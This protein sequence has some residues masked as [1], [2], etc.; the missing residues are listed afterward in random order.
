MEIPK[1]RHLTEQAESQR[2]LIFRPVLGQGNFI[3]R[4]LC[5]VQP[6]PPRRCAHHPGWNTQYD[7]VLAAIDTYSDRSIFHSLGD[8]DLERV[9]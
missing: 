7:T 9:F 3:D 2:M 8:G 6:S 5:D 1:E 4:H